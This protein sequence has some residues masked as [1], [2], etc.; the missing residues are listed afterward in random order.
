MKIRSC[1]FKP[2]VSY[3]QVKRPIDWQSQFNDDAPLEVEIGF[4]MGETLIRSAQKFPDRN[5]IGIEQHWAQIYRALSRI[6]TWQNS[7]NPPRRENIKILNIDARCAFERLFP[8]QT[9]D[10]V[11]SL[12]PCPWPK[13]KHAKHRLFSHE[14]LKLLNSRLKDKGTLEIVTDY[15]PYQQ[16][17]LEEADNTGL[18]VETRS[19]K[20]QFDTK[21]ERKWLATGQKEF[22]EIKLAKIF[23]Q[24]IPVSGD[25]ILKAY[26]LK[27]FDPAKFKFVD[28]KDEV[29]IIFKDLFF[30]AGKNEALVYVIVAEEN[31]TQNFWVTID[32]KNGNWRV[33]KTEGQDFFPTPGIHLAMQCVFEAAAATSSKN[34]GVS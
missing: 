19:I 8:P 27:H 2:L 20:P 13:K 1:S 16:W 22:F 10:R 26:K 33:K 3:Y 4:G 31:L 7:V 15:Y 30:D 21:Y 23:H 11:Y 9:I 24:D 5:F 12:F 28:H 18:G 34:T 25:V 29:S 32:Q 14:F 6:T 17:I